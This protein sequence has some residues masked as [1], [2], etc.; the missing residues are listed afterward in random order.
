MSAYIV[1]APMTCARPG[2]DWKGGLVSHWRALFGPP[3][4]ITIPVEL[5]SE[6]ALLAY[7]GLGAP[8]LKKIWYYRAR[9]YQHF[10][11]AKGSNKVRTISAPDRRTAP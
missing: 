5:A 1:R 7:L 9:M 2:R 6:T 4:R 10:S 3:I 11:V 8:E